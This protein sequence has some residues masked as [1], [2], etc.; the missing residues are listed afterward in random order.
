[1][2][3]SAVPRVIWQLERVVRELEALHD[4]EVAAWRGRTAPGAAATQSE[5][6]QW[7]DDGTQSYGRC[8]GLEAAIVVVNNAR[9]AYARKHVNG[10]RL[11]RP[12]DDP[13]AAADL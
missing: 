13:A 3:D 9:D 11:V 12:V 6:N 7:S 1:M 4:A 5:R 2:S 8:Q 10:H